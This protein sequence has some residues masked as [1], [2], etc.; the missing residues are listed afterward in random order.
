MK[1]NASFAYFQKS[2]D[3]KKYCDAKLNLVQSFII[4]CI[5]ISV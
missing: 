1:N 5:A 2:L 4:A 3:C